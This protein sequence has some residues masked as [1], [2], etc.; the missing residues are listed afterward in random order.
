MLVK[1][2]RYGRKFNNH[3]SLNFISLVVFATKHLIHCARSRILLIY[4]LFPESLLEIASV[5]TE[6]LDALSVLIVRIH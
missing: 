3:L 6:I 5:K 1:I 4:R 2:Y